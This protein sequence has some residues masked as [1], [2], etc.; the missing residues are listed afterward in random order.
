M[1]LPVD[2]LLQEYQLNIMQDIHYTTKEVQV[3]KARMG[4]YTSAV[5]EGAK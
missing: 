2:W 5:L 4:L 1:R 3:I